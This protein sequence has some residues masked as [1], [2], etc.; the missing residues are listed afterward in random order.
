MCT[1]SLALNIVLIISYN[2][3]TWIKWLIIIY[4]KLDQSWA[5]LEVLK[6]RFEFVALLLEEE[7]DSWERSC[8]LTNKEV[9]W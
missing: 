6:L 2:F 9:D 3:L 4:L 1:Y 7:I 8:M 5:V